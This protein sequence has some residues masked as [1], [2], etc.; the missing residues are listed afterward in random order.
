VKAFVVPVV[1]ALC[2]SPLLAQAPSIQSPAAKPVASKPAKRLSDEWVVV[3]AKSSIAYSGTHAG[4][5]FNGTFSSWTAA[6]RFD[7]AKLAEANA[8]V[9]IMLASSKTGDKT[10]DET[11]PGDDW[12]DVAKTPVAMFQSQRFRA[13]E[14]G[15]YV[16][17]GVLTMRN[18]KVPVSL[19]FSLT[20]VGNSA[21]MS[22]QVTLKRMA[23]GLGKTSDAAGDW[24]GLD[25]P[26]TI[27]VTALRKK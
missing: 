9:R 2:V 17:D 26:V 21:T 8:T 12:F 6:I 13:T 3:P 10:Y 7:P 19:P 14:P 22:G 16:A 1:A 24:V 23:F 25:I 15:K 18:V 5:I 27:K 11:L 20:I 4:R